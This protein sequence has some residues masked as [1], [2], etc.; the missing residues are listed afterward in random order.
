[1]S[2]ALALTWKGNPLTWTK[3]GENIIPKS[4]ASGRNK[5]QE[6]KRERGRKEEEKG[7]LKG[8]KERERTSKESMP[9]S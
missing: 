6:G 5:E 7:E 1:M 4:T 2:W 9:F 3:C 8:G